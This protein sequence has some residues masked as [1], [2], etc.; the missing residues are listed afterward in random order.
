MCKSSPIASP[1]SGVFLNQ[2]MSLG[3]CP[4]LRPPPHRPRRSHQHVRGRRWLLLLTVIAVSASAGAR[5]QS[6]DEREHQTVVTPTPSSQDWT[7]ASTVIPR[8]RLEQTG[9]DTARVLDEEAGLRVTRLG[10]LGAF[11][12][13]SIRGSTADQVRLFVD[14][15]PL[16]SAEGGPVDLATL[17]L[18]PMSSIHIHR[19]S[20]PII[21]GPSAIGGVIDI[22]TRT[23]AA[24]R[25][26]IHTGLGSLVSRVIR[27]FYGAGGA[28]ASAGISMDYSGSHGDFSYLSDNGTA[29]DTTDDQELIRTNNAF[30]QFSTLFKAQ[31]DPG[32]GVRLTVLD[33]LTW[34]RRGLPGVGLYQTERSRL[35][36][37]RNLLGARLEVARR[38]FQLGVSGY[39][40][41]SQT[42]LDDPLNEVGLGAGSSARQSWV[43]GVDLAC[44]FPVA[45]DDEAAWRLVGVTALSYRLDRY[46]P[47]Q[48]APRLRH[49][50]AVGGELTLKASPLNTDLVASMRYEGGVGSVE[51]VAPSN[52]SSSALDHHDVSWRAA[53]VNRSLPDTR[54]SVGV[55]RNVRLPSL[56]ELYG[57]NGYVLG[58]PDLQAEDGLTVEL[59][60]THFA[61][62][63]GDDTVL[64]IDLAGHMTWTEELIQF[65]QNAQGTARPENVDAAFVAGVEVAAR[66]DVLRHLR[67]RTALTWL[68][69][70]NQSAITARTGKQ[71]PFR[72]RWSFY[73][74][75]EGYFDVGS[76]AVGELAAWIDVDVTTGNM[77]DHANLVE[78]PQRVLVGVG[79]HAEF[80]DRQLRLGVSGRNLT[81]ASAQDLAGFPLPGPS[82]FASLTWRPALDDEGS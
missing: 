64:A 46:E 18:G 13:L 17:P 75:V 62:W 59:A 15:I 33:M 60:A 19:G 81:S 68:H 73:G 77:L 82:W 38:S 3:R 4:G 65:V 8:S 79:V 52:V 40:G 35:T 11:S 67:A 28:K 6:S 24:H 63:A 44:R 1:I 69:S 37:L 12:R 32:P 48:Q 16:S 9:V 45:L 31:L 27:G 43:P 66:V 72:P 25:L 30:N 78:V 54:I 2:I 21:Y 5:A 34:S 29:F 53:V 80:W 39:V 70:V 14:G 56:Y 10:G 61:T 20:S 76:A 41:W 36:R 22:R 71:L 23:L 58:N 47:Q 51:D 26:D 7:P 50:V 74:R 55:A 42:R 49:V 57:D